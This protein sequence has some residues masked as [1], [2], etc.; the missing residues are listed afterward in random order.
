MTKTLKCT[1]GT[2]VASMVS[3][4]GVA[5]S[6]IAAPSATADNNSYL[7]ALRGLGLT[8]EEGDAGAL[9]VGK[10]ACAL[11]APGPGLLYGRHPNY[12]AQI[13]WEKNPMLERHQAA[14]LVNAAIDNL[15]PGVNLMGHATV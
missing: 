11:L 14:Q 15:C 2:A 13:V 10:G 12:V 1:A 5:V 7:D 6:L 3:A 8:A 9:K 4:F